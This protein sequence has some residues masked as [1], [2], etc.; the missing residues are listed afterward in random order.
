M[1]A[2]WR[3][4]ASDDRRHQ[5]AHSTS[6]A[7]LSTNP[8]LNCDARIVAPHD[9]AVRRQDERDLMASKGHTAPSQTPL[10][11]EREVEHGA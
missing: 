8:K 1:G 7:S 5:S 6:T 11:R 4:P 9:L 10:A 2:L 3:L